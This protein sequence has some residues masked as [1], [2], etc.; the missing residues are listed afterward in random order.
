MHHLQSLQVLRMII[1]RLGQ[2]PKLVEEHSIQLKEQKI[3][4]MLK[5]GHSTLM[6]VRSILVLVHSMIVEEHCFRD[7]WLNLKV[8]QTKFEL[9]L[10]AKILR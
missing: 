8:P 4:Q 5:M 10:L 6:L 2:F 1:L 9:V 3:Q 7:R